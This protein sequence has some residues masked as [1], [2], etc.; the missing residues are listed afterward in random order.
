MILF[1]SAFFYSGAQNGGKITIKGEILD[2][3]L[4]KNYGK[5]PKSAK[6]F[7]KYSFGKSNDTKVYETPEVLNG[8]RLI[9]GCNGKIALIEVE[10]DMDLIVEI[11]KDRIIVNGTKKNEYLADWQE[12]A[13]N[14]FPNRAKVRLGAQ[15]MFA[16]NAVYPKDDDLF[17]PEMY[18]FLDELESKCLKQLSKAK[19]E[20]E[21]FVAQ[22]KLVIKYHKLEVLNANYIYAKYRQLQTPPHFITTIESIKFDNPDLINHHNGY[23]IMEDYF[24]VLK[25]ECKLFTNADTEIYDKSMK[26]SN[27]ELREF[28]A[29]S[30]LR[31][32]I[33]YKTYFRIN[34]IV[35]CCKPIFTTSKGVT[36]YSNIVD[37]ISNIKSLKN[38]EGSDAFNFA[39][40]NEKGEIVKL[41][42][43]KGK[44]VLIDIWATWCG[45]CKAQIPH[46]LE[47]EKK[48]KGENIQFVS[49]SADKQKDKELWLKYI[50]DNNMHGCTL[51][52]DKDF[53]SDMMKFYSVN[54]IPRFILIDP[55]GKLISDNC[56]QIGNSTFQQYLIDLVTK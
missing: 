11:R 49:I 44:F 31:K 29:I 30:C 2:T 32:L 52:A 25:G 24:R 10:P 37:Y 48:M 42:D 14:S 54:A 6:N 28:Y 39:F 12:L 23:T 55:Q 45:P 15:N 18:K 7:M 22:Q 35:K 21:K 50:K 19:I 34:E 26:I 53:K 17:K 38:V 56:L 33:D 51:I 41:S 43:F 1:L 5:S 8:E 20:D 3:L 40:E 16:R 9:L 46:L 36:D 4:I 13:Y 27:Q 47:M